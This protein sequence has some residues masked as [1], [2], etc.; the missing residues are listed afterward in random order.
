M[1]RFTRLSILWALLSLTAVVGVAVALGSG[2]SPSRPESAAS[3]DTAAPPASSAEIPYPYNTS[4]RIGP[5]G[6]Y[7]QHAT[8]YVAWRFFQRGISFSANM[9]GPGGK[10]GHFGDPSMWPVNAAAI[11]F[12]V[13]ARPTVGS[14]AQWGAGEQG[15]P[16]TGH[17]AYVERVN[18]DGSVVVSEFDWSV[19]HGYSQRGQAG[20]SAVRAPRYIHV[21][22]Q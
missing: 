11:G 13:D 1:R 21:L 18:A 16:G 7:T 9:A 10:V 5:W 6:F 2:A 15:A 19:A 3:A 8:D 4:T 20:T 14:I 17:V 12:K 22:D